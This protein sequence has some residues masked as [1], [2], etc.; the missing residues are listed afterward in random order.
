MRLSGNGELLRFDR[1]SRTW[2]VP[3]AEMQKAPVMTTASGVVI[4]YLDPASFEVREEDIAYA[5]ENI[6]R[7]N[8]ARRVQLLLHFALCTKLATSVPGVSARRIGLVG[9][10]DFAETVLGDIVTGLK[11]LLPDY[12]ALE[13]GWEHRF[14]E[15]FGYADPTPEDEAFIRYIDLR[16]LVI[17]THC[18]AH[19]VAEI[20]AHQH[21]G[22]PTRGELDLFGY[23]LHAGP[24]LQWEITI[25]AV[26]AG[27]ES[28]I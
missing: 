13:G 15:H 27:R 16:A 8:G 5:A 1:E 10:H 19:P 22:K 11:R 12:R 21:G 14:R 20:A 28:L 9:L 2:N 4:D 6:C 24:R 25:D 17:E 3:I 7:Y 23:L 18:T 26:R